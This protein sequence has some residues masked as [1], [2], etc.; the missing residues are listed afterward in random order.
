MAKRP[1]VMK[2]D[3]YPD[4]FDAKTA[5]M[6]CAEVG[7]YVRLLNHA[8]KQDDG[9]LPDNWKALSRVIR[10]RSIALTVTEKFRTR[11]N[12]RLANERALQEFEISRNRLQAHID[13]GSKGG[14]AKAA[15]P[16][17]ARPEPEAEVKPDSSATVTSSSSSS[18]STSSQRMNEGEREASQPFVS[19]QDCQDCEALHGRPC[20]RHKSNLDANA[21]SE[22]VPVEK[23][24]PRPDVKAL[25]LGLA[26][27]LHGKVVDSWYPDAEACLYVFSVDDLLAMAKWA[28][29]QPE[30]KNGFS[31]RK[32]ILDMKSWRRIVE[33]GE[34]AKRWIAD[35]ES[36]CQDPLEPQPAKKE[37]EPRWK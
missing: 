22:P 27:L 37:R 29:A 21:D 14:R 20:Y 9:M 24:E 26:A 10:C 7:Q 34:L 8:W 6:T 35:R 30:G 33:K 5:H 2:V 28:C 36:R 16:S 3:W 13:K 19:S 23:P 32:R 1:K 31:W 11:E 18:S 15:K 17:P 4:D 12:N 25:C